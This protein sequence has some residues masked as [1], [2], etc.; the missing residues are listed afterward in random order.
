M[1]SD[2]KTEF[3]A[4]LNMA[5]KTINGSKPDGELLA[6]WWSKFEGYNIADLR[7]AFSLVTD[8]D[9]IRLTPAKLYNHLPSKYG[10]PG[11]EEAFTHLINTI[12]H[13]G[14]LSDEIRE[15]WGA[16]SAHLEAKDRVAARMAFKEKYEALV[17]VATNRPKWGWYQ[18]SGMDFDDQQR[19]KKFLLGRLGEKGWISK[20]ETSNLLEALSPKQDELLITQEKQKENVKAIKNLIASGL[21]ATKPV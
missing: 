15:A 14:Y 7:K 10:H 8:E 1:V 18:S 19:E 4:L 2:D 17:R 16:C 5:H 11:A 12:D 9:I 20:Q 6:M 3:F 13:H 21:N